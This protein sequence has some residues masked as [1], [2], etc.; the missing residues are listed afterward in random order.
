M[1]LPLT[2]FDRGI[3]AGGAHRHVK[4]GGYSA[5]ERELS[6]RG[7]DLGRV[8]RISH[9]SEH[10]LAFVVLGTRL[11]SHGTSCPNRRAEARVRSPRAFGYCSR[12]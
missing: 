2:A 4:E 12:G 7:P 8:W 5:D 6:R 10:L 1:L 3:E 9:R 11:G